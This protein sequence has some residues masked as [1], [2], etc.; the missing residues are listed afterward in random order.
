MFCVLMSS[1]FS[2]LYHCANR[3]LASILL[4]SFRVCDYYDLYTISPSFFRPGTPHARPP[5][6]DI[7]NVTQLNLRCLIMGLPFC[8]LGHLFTLFDLANQSL[9]FLPESLGLCSRSGDYDY[10]MLYLR[11]CVPIT[12]I[13]SLDRFH[14]ARWNPGE[15]I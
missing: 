14:G 6:C 3:L 13:I 7:P 4:V 1:S 2:L 12:S 9:L 11:R 8:D 5:L 15:N 10:V